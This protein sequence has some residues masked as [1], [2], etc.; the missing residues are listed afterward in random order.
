[1]Y[2]SVLRSTTRALESFVH[3]QMLIRASLSREREWGARHGLRPRPILFF[4]SWDRRHRTGT[5]RTAGSRGPRDTVLRT[6][7]CTGKLLSTE[8]SCVYVFI[9]CHLLLLFLP[10]LAA[11]LMF[12]SIV[13]K[14][15]PVFGLSLQCVLVLHN[16]HVPLER[17]YYSYSLE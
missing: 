8:Q 1:M 9:Y 2:C 10:Q 14:R 12:S 13:L 17:Y 3:Q 4:R 11:F 16:T 7:E 5:G 6:V 15:S